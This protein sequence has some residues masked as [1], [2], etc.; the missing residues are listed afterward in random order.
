MRTPFDETWN[1]WVKVSVANHFKTLESD[2][3]FFVEGFERDTNGEQDWIEVRLDGPY[4][5]ELTKDRWKLYIEVNIICC[6]AENNNNAY[7][8]DEI[9]GLVVKR[10][11]DCISV[12]QGLVSPVL[13]GCLDLVPFN[14]RQKI[15]VNNF[16]KLRPDTRFIQS[17]VEGHYQMFID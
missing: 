2:T 4:V 8:M 9:T 7:R 6:V 3:F 1:R 15:L 17:S 13:I 5:T 12:H 14:A 10:M 16:G 11:L